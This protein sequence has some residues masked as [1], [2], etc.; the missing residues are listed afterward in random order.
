MTPIPGAPLPVNAIIVVPFVLA[1]FALV[2]G[3]FTGD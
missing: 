1:N 2:L 3:F